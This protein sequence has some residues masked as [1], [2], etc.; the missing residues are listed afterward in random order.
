MYHLSDKLSGNAKTG[1]MVVTTTGAQ[2]CPPTCPLRGAGCYAEMG[3]LALH[4]RKVTS[5]ERGFS[6]WYQFVDVLTSTLTVWRKRAATSY[7]RHNQAGDLPSLASGGV[8]TA[9]AIADLDNASAEA[10]VRGFT[11]TH[12]AITHTIAAAIKAS[13][14]FTVNVSCET[15]EQVDAAIA[16]GLPAVV[17]VQ[18]DA[19]KVTRTPAGNRI[20][21][22]P[23]QVREDVS[24][25]SCG[26]CARKDRDYAIG[27]RAHGARWKA[28]DRSLA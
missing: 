19:P 10:G 20:V 12:H 5:G 8:D 18:S 6:D 25:V 13:R 22:C 9:I 14:F 1:P 11:Y 15:G 17:V 28:I 4:W 26:L 21:V 27:F 16:R 24:C 3:S 7:W 23:A 2:T